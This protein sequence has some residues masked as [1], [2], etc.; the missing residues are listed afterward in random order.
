M[1]K[2]KV[3]SMLL[4]LGLGLTATF[5]FKAHKT[6]E[7]IGV[8]NG[9]YSYVQSNLYIEFT[10]LNASD[11]QDG[12]TGKYTCTEDPGF[13][14]EINYTGTPSFSDGADLILP[15]ADV[16]FTSIDKIPVVNP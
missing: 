11:F 5:A 8:E 9:T 4:A 13:L 14:C 12:V 15:V 7:V 1:K 6:G 2:I 3:F 10:A 16:T